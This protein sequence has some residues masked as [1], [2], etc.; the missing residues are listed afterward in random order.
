MPRVEYG[1]FEPCKVGDGVVEVVE[2][3]KEREVEVEVE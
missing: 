1:L 2:K 3:W